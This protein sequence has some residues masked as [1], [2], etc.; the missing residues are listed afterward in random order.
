MLQKSIRGIRRKNVV[1]SKYSFLYS[2]HFLDSDYQIRPGATTKLL[3]ENAISSVFK[4]FPVH[5]QKSL[6]V[7]QRILQRNIPDIVSTYLSFVN[8][9]PQFER[10]YFVD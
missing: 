1:P 2:E 9:L 6:P 8:T 3:N 10:I 5:L 7:R 4:G